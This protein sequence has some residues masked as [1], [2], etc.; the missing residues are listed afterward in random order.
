[1][2]VFGLG[3]S[4]ISASLALA[5]GGVRVHA[6]DDDPARR[7]HAASLGVAL[8]DLYR[9]EWDD[10]VALVLSPGV[11]LSHPAPHP[12]VARALTSGLEILGDMELF[13]RSR[14]PGRVVGVTGTNGKSTTATL[15]AHL[16][17]A[18]GLRVQLGGNIGTP[19]LDLKPL[20]A[21][22]VYVLELSSYQLDLVR[23]LVSDVAVLLNIAPDHLER[24]GGFANYIASKTRIFSR[25]ASS[26]IAVLGLDDDVCRRIHAELAGRRQRRIVPVAVG[27][28]VAGGVYV[29]E[30][31]V[32]TD[33]TGGEAVE[34]VE[35]ARLRA[36]LGVHN[37]QNAAAAYGAIRALGLPG[38]NL[39]RAFRR[40][41]GLAHRQEAITRIGKVAFV[42]DSKATNAPAAARALACF[43][44]IY[45]IAGGRAKAGGVATLAPLF[46]RMAHA[47]LIGEA[48]GAFAQT[49]EGRVPCTICGDLET[50]FAAATERAFAEQRAEPVVLLSPAC[51][52]LDQFENFEQRGDRF[53]ELVVDE[54]VRRTPPKKAASKTG[55]GAEAG[56]GAGKAPTKTGAK[57]APPKKAGAKTAGGKTAGGK[58]SG[59]G[60]GT[61]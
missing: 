57:K 34:V 61:T 13:A 58:T 43:R 4:G 35:L 28:R 36:L 2:A 20:S 7:R 19:V 17:R 1:M 41:S 12:L 47:F 51:A 25:R 42:N 53:R 48:A 15:I 8:A 3:R 9:I 38:D 5:R 39:V 50:A 10:F 11:P 49:L 52:S 56:A 18:S 30:D 59:A 40:F 45:W 26:Q 27:R 46:P 60:A 55:T 31:G 6:W 33:E 32:L 54:K 23:T 14:P 29:T 24:H 21:E 16:I 44:D 22:G 37:Q